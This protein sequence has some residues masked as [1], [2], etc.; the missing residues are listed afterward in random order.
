M[1]ATLAVWNGKRK[2]Y[3]MQN[4]ILPAD[5]YECETWRFNSRKDPDKFFEK[6][7]AEKTSTEECERS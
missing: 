3:N 6:F 1:S 4:Y 5:I 2:D 7:T